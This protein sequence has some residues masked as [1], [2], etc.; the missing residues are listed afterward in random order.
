MNPLL[1]GKLRKKKGLLLLTV[2]FLFLLT[3]GPGLESGQAPS[4]KK[5]APSGKIIILD[6]LSINSAPLYV[7]LHNGYFRQEGVEVT[8]R[9]FPSGK[10]ALDAVRKGGGDLATVADIP[11]MYAVM[12]GAPISVV[13][14]ISEAFRESA[15][16][17]RKDH[18]IRSERDLQGKKIGVA[19]GTITDYF[20]DGL[21]IFNRISREQI[22]AIFLPPDQIPGA[23]EK[24]KIDAAV[25]WTPYVPKLQEKLGANIKIYYGKG[26]YRMLWN[27]V[28]LQDRVAG[29][30]ETI[31]KILRALMSG[32]AFIREKPD[33]AGK[34]VAGYL[35]LSEAQVLE[36][37]SNYRFQVALPPQ[38]LMNLE[39]QTRWAIRNGT[40]PKKPVPNF[41]HYLYFE[42]LQKVDPEAVTILH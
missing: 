1:P 41:L 6:G 27:L 25:T 15:L 40:V 26:I 39:N 14:T 9:L 10:A 21:L 30:P 28:G 12:E 32:V 24:G 16:V 29:K 38:L 2:F 17:A 8:C 33:E 23:L 37:W 4:N 31:Q 5:S 7:A 3:A 11:I 18:G 22:T 34:I 42:G 35:G 19:P 20:L 13:A 36:V